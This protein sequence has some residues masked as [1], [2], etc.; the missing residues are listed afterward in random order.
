M[1]YFWQE[2]Y[3]FEFMGVLPVWDETIQTLIANPNRH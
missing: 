2:L 1:R 3:L